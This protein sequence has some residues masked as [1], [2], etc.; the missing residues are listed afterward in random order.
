MFKRSVT[1]EK[2]AQSQSKYADV[3]D[4]FIVF[5]LLHSLSLVVPQAEELIFSLFS[6]EEDGELSL[7]VN[8]IL[9]F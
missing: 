7:S 2:V 9:C 3:R 8:S 1:G 4:N 6:N 5:E